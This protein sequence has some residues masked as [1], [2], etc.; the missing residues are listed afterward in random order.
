M[1]EKAVHILIIQFRAGFIQRGGRYTG[2]DHKPHIHRKLFSGSQHIVDT[3][4]VHD[5]GDLMGVG[6]DRSGA[7]G[8]HR[9]GKFSGA[10][11]TGFQMDVSVNKAGTDDF[12]RHIHF[13]QAVVTS[14]THN[15]TMGN[16]NIFGHQFPGKHIHI[17]GIFQ[18][19]IRF[20][21]AGCHVDDLLLLNKLSA[22]LTGPAFFC[23]HRRFLLTL[24]FYDTIKETIYKIKNCKY[25]L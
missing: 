16:G 1:V 4:C 24:S 25:F 2:G 21:A 7:V 17:G 19:Q 8:D 22:D 6:D 12:S 9:P 15:E 3:R 23:C 14:Q 18:H 13:L 5:V 10:D 20:F 11:Q